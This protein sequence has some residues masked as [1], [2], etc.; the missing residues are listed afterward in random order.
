MTAIA[1]E[2]ENARFVSWQ[3]IVANKKLCHH[4]VIEGN[5]GE[6]GGEMVWMEGRDTYVDVDGISRIT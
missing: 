6:C 5:T 2:R 4:A 3:H 1:Q